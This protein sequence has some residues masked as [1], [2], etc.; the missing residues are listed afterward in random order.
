MTVR[1]FRVLAV[2]VIGL[3]VASQGCLVPWSKY[4]KLKK[5]YQQ[6]AGEVER[7]DSEL[8]DAHE[9][10][11]SL[12]EELRSKD[13]LIGLY[14]DKKRDATLLAEQTRKRLE[15][16]QEKLRKIAD[17]AGPNVELGEGVLK[18][19][20]E[21][22]F[23]LGSADISPDG[24]KVL[25]DI[26]TEFKNTDTII[27]I[28]GHTDDHK[29]SK[30]ETVKK[31]KDNWG[32][33]AARARAVLKLLAKSGVPE[34]RMYLRAFSMFRPRVPNTDEA[35]RAKNRRVEVYFLP[36]ELTASAPAKPKTE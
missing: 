22:L 20:D 27:R 21:L 30:P 23:A 32:L 14:E 34:R 19:K 31:F 25:Q 18:I 12:T 28:D 7:K 10:I 3:S 13:Q 36:P 15:E 4:I 11:D 9:R 8:A 26:A 29:V 2:G 24:Q 35:N 6:V 16:V 1:V 33:A 17:R 5:Q